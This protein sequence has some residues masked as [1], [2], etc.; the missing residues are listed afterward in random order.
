MSMIIEGQAYYEWPE[1]EPKIGTRVKVASSGSAGTVRYQGK[2]EG[3]GEEIW[4][5]VELDEERGKND[6]SVG[7]LSYFS[8]R[9]NH[10]I[11][12]RSSAFVPENFV[13][14][15]KKK[16]SKQRPSVERKTSAL[17]A[18]KD[19]SSDGTLKMMSVLVEK[20][21]VT[22]DGLHQRMISQERKLIQKL[23]DDVSIILRA[24]EI[25][26]VNRIHDEISSQLA[27]IPDYRCVR[28][29]R[30]HSEDDE[31]NS[32]AGESARSACSSFLSSTSEWFLQPHQSFLGGRDPT[33]DH[34]A[35]SASDS[36]QHWS[37]R[38]SKDDTSITPG[39]NIIVTMADGN[40][41]PATPSTISGVSRGSMVS[42]CSSMLS[43]AAAQHL[44]DLQSGNHL[45]A[46]RMS[47]MH[48]NVSRESVRLA[49]QDLLRH[50]CS[51]VTL[52]SVRFRRQD[53]SASD[54]SSSVSLPKD[55]KIISNQSS[56]VDFQTLEFPVS[57]PSS[58]VD[59]QTLEFPAKDFA[60]EAGMMSNVSSVV[61]LQ[62][63]EVPDLDEEAK[64][65]P[66]RCS[67][68]E[69]KM[70]ADCSS[71]VDLQSSES[72]AK[73]LL[74]PAASSH[75]S[76]PPK[77]GPSTAKTTPFTD[78]CVSMES[79][80]SGSSSC[81]SSIESPRNLGNGTEDL[82]EIH[83]T[84]AEAGEQGEVDIPAMPASSVQSGPSQDES[85]TW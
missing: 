27:Q 8:C 56:V 60:E 51:S 72:S 10:G 48:S 17:T 74:S 5:G 44:D 76:Y 18:A 55:A 35:S 64:M 73:D 33:P 59:F 29:P 34:S 46:K 82:P 16:K 69:P 78:T 84:F 11:F 7:D 81:V 70:V 9:R 61:D 3:K 13:P 75:F 68:R 62:T 57:N 43:T 52:D 21:L 1:G 20:T 85:E 50:R 4:L 40:A 79:K 71:M 67:A 15:K 63:L 6:G 30:Q 22:V 53:S 25:H 2:I 14:E 31:R 37:P 49:K 36:E 77:Q 65:V 54:S 47:S 32:H 42:Y 24:Q 66:T 26:L 38:R 80:V 45:R 23:H 39:P 19:D 83:I 28:S 12:S 58:V 41:R